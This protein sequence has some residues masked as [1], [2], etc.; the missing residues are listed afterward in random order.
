MEPITPTPTPPDPET[1]DQIDLMPLRNLLTTMESIDPNGVLSDDEMSTAIN[2][3]RF[4]DLDGN[5]EVNSAE[6]LAIFNR[7]KAFNE[8]KDL[9]SNVMKGDYSN[10]SESTLAELFDLSE[11]IRNIRS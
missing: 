3:P 7:I 8:D 11:T 5:P 6:E 1:P 4:S 10:I 2:N 9:I